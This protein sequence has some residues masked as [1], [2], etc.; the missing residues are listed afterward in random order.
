MA[1]EMSN[2]WSAFQ[3]RTSAWWKLHRLAT[4]SAATSF[5]A[6]LSISGATST[7][8][9]RDAQPG[10]ETG[11]GRW[12]GES[13]QLPPGGRSELESGPEVRHLDRHRSVGLHCRSA[14]TLADHPRVHGRKVSFRVAPVLDVAHAHSQSASY[15]GGLPGLLLPQA[16]GLQDAAGSGIS[17]GLLRDG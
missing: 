1:I 2:L 9:T 17:G 6:R 16:A 13:V 4:P 5:R 11:R 14:G 8:V 3:F 7:P 15:T 12:R 10:A